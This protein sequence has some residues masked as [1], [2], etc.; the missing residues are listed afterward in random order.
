MKLVG[1]SFKRIKYQNMKMDSIIFDVDGT[2]WNACIACAKGW[3]EGLEELG[4]SLRV[5]AEDIESVAGRPQ[6]ECID[7]LLPDLRKR[8]PKS[9]QLLS[10]KENI[11]IGK[12]GGDFYKGVFEG[13]EKLSA[14]Y[15]L[16]I[17]SN[18]R[19]DYLEIFF[20]FA[21]FKELMKGYD[22]YGMSKLSKCGM[23]EKMR[24]NF[25]LK[26]PVYVGDTEVDEEAARLAQIEFIYAAYGFGKP[27][28]KHLS[29]SDFVSMTNYFL[30]KF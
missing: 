25:Q 16:F 4:V 1:K 18:A 23:L 21:G 9:S 20:K 10:E 22:C 3:N 6:E 7:I 28:D 19:Q 2:L 12:E 14:K 8:Y 30:E 24:K 26:N 11:Y 29:F 17:V 13:I 5:S 27:K 15:P